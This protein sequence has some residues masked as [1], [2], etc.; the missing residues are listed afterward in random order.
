MRIVNKGFT[1]IELVMVIVILGVLAATALPKFVS[2][3]GDAQAAKMKALEGAMR[4]AVTIAKAQYEVEGKPASIT[5]EG[6]NIPF[7]NGWPSGIGWLLLLPSDNGYRGSFTGGFT[8]AYAY[9][10]TSASMGVGSPC[11]VSYTQAASAGAAP[12][13]ANSIS[14]ANC[15]GF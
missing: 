6:V 12:T 2:L 11:V 9:P 7:V 5:L 4:S 1:L 13:W 10:N 15:E 8:T 3:K 14:S